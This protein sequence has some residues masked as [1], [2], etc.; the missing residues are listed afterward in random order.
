MKLAGYSPMSAGLHEARSIAGAQVP[1]LA[2]PGS[3]AAG[4]NNHDGIRIFFDAESRNCAN[5][6]VSS[7]TGRRRKSVLPHLS[8]IHIPTYCGEVPLLE[9]PKRVRTEVVIL[10]HQSSCVTHGIG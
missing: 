10:F 7:V 1:L 8:R 3:L 5:A 9:M 4:G 2:R 6:D